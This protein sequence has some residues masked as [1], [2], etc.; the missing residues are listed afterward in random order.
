MRKL[1]LATILCLS[2]TAACA[3][4]ITGDIVLRPLA[5]IDGTG[6]TQTVTFT[7]PPG[8]QIFPPAF[9]TGNFLTFGADSTFAMNP[10]GSPI[11]WQ[12]F[13]GNVVTGLSG[14]GLSSWS[15][16]AQAHST[17]IHTA[18]HFEIL[19]YG[20][21]I[22]TGFQPTLTHFWLDWDRPVTDIHFPPPPPVIQFVLSATGLE[23][24]ATVPGPIVGTGLPG[25]A[26]LGLLWLAR[27]RQRG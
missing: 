6:N 22:M 26:A 23:P 20:T 14:D 17:D 21:L 13:L 18:D 1:L 19:G 27:R 12:D 15:F 7:L 2:T 8:S 10:T 5:T 25:L 4:F 3:D 11:A 24:P 16:D 9:Q